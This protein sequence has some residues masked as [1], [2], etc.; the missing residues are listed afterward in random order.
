MDIL[1]SPRKKGLLPPSLSR[2]TVCF[3]CYHLLFY[4]SAFLSFLYFFLFSTL[5]TQQVLFSHSTNCCSYC[6][7]SSKHLSKNMHPKFIIASY[8]T[9]FCGR[10]SF[11]KNVRIFKAHAS[12]SRFQ[13]CFQLL[14]NEKS[15]P[16]NK[17]W[18]HLLF[19][20][21]R[22]LFSPKVHHVLSIMTL[23]WG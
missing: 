14:Q 23:S 7:L 17:Y 10:C 21:S 18:G 19:C 3:C 13:K 1:V 15:V 4:Y 12:V 6:E 5:S 22:F 20:L 9:A 16:S 2:H 8:V 11:H